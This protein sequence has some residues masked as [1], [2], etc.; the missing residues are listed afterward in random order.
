MS[1]CVT[2]RVHRAQHELRFAVQF[3]DLVVLDKTIDLNVA[4]KLR[5]LFV[6][7]GGNNAAEMRLQCVHSRDWIR[8][9]MREDD[10]AYLAPRCNRLVT[11]LR[12]HLL[13]L[14]VRRSRVDDQQLVLGMDE[15]AAGVS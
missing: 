4:E 15:V 5:G 1:A 2:G 12:Q 10:L 3:D 14:F 6:S 8:M 11:A 7:S 9:M 13:F